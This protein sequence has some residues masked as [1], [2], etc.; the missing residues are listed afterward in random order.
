MNWNMKKILFGL[1]ALSVGAFSSCSNDDIEITTTTAP[2]QDALTISVDISKFYSGYTFDDTKHNIDQIAEAYRTFNSENEMFIEVRTLIYNKSTEALV[3]SIVN[4]VSNT[5]AV[6]AS[7]SLLPGDYYAITT[8]TFATKNKVSYWKLEDKE[9]ISTAKLSP[10]NRYNKWSILSI[11]TDNFSVTRTQQARVNT[12]PSPL[13]TL[14]YFYF[15]NFQ[16]IDEASY[17]IVADNKVRRIALYT[18][19]RADSYNL[20]PNATSKFNYAKETE[21]GSW[22]PDKVLEPDDFDDGSWTH[23]K[24][25]LYSYTYVLEPEQHTTF[26][27]M[28]EG[29]SG[30]SGYGEQNTSF[31][32]GTTYLAY[33]DYFKIGNPYLGVADNNHWN[34]YQVKMLY[35]EPYTEWG[36]SLNVVKG[37]MAAKK[38][39]LYSEGDNYLLYYGKYQE[40]A[41]EYD[42]DN[43][44]KLFAAYIYLDTTISLTSLSNN[45]AKNSGAE[46]YGTLDDGTIVYVTSDNKTYILIYEYTFSDGSKTNIV[47]YGDNM[48]SASPRMAS[49]RVK[50]SSRISM[51]LQQ[52]HK[53]QHLFQHN[54]YK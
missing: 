45:V 19:R 49:R 40:N 9:K 47:Q 48:A 21:S 36:A 7:K 10:K 50:P 52:D 39:E 5:N 53:S 38:Y 23:F 14:V 32:P 11:S 3:D 30:F 20:D 22:Y 33:W 18:Q 2:V 34:D 31:T 27:L 12:I 54:R 43:S 37:Q 41:S 4:Y 25:N 46:Y 42:F 1:I 6:T 28:R 24:S 44:G 13:G 17:G 35:E 26:G 16:Y 29:D 15:Q 51:N 8:L